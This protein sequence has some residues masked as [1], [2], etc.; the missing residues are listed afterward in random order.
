MARVR[1][2]DKFTISTQNVIPQLTYA[3]IDGLVT[4]VVVGAAAIPDDEYTVS[5]QTVTWDEVSAG[6]DLEVGDVAV[7]DYEYENGISGDAP[8]YDEESSSS[9]P[10]EIS[11]N[12]TVAETNTVPRL[13]HVPVSSTFSMLVNGG[14]TTAGVDW[15]RNGKNVTWTSATTLNIN[16]I[17][18]VEYRINQ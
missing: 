17:V 15:T 6:Y 4:M 13:I 16:D 9:N 7:I 2:I 11:Y 5:G 1:V 8:P 3:P 14:S 10:V 12:L 18:S